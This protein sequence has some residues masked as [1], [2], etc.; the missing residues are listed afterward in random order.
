[1]WNTNLYSAYNISTDIWILR[2]SFILSVF[3]RIENSEVFLPK[4]WDFILNTLDKKYT[5]E[6]W[7]KSK[8]KKQIY[9][10]KNSFVISDNIIVW[11]INK[12]PLWLFWLIK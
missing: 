8:N 3:N 7:W 10:T 2:E 9:N 5:F 11:E 12:I 1:L 6:I 4:S